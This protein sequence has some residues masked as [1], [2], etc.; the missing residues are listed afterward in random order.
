M[1]PPQPLIFLALLSMTAVLAACAR[2]PNDTAGSVSLAGDFST[3]IQIHIDN[4]VRRQP[5]AVY[6]SP[7]GRLDHKP[8]ALFVPLRFTAGQQP[9]ELQRHGFTPD[10]AGMAFP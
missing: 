6:V 7:R 8:R 4:F 9:H 1:K 5:P 10:M 3:P 2:E